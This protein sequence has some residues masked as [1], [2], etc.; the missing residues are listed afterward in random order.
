MIK[1]DFGLLELDNLSAEFG[2]LSLELGDIIFEAVF[3]PLES[4]D[5]SIKFD[6]IT[7]EPSDPPHQLVV[8]GLEL[9]D[10]YTQRIIVGLEDAQVSHEVSIPSLQLSEGGL[11]VVEV[12]GL[13]LVNALHAQDLRL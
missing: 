2:I 3:L 5:F 11:K 12:P 10:I 1:V 6:I 8:G 13:D 9:G 7:V 4:F